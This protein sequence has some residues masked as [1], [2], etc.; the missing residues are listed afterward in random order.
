VIADAG[1]TVV[2]QNESI[3]R[4]LMAARAGTTIVVEPGEYRE[5]LQLKSH[6]RLMSRV[7]RGAV[8]R[9]PGAASEAAAAIVARGVQDA[10]VEGFR[11]V[12]DAA[13]PLGTGILASESE[14][15]ISQVEIS[16]AAKAA[17]DVDKGSRVRAVANEIHDN[18]GA[19][20]AIRAGATATITHNRFA[21]NATAGRA[22]KALIVDANAT[23]QFV[24]NV[25]AVSAPGALGWPGASHPAFIRDNF[26]DSRPQTPARPPSSGR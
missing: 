9:L 24:S 11:I 18:P 10:A 5:T 14:L 1:T 23:V 8:L 21:R 17:I 15:S 2:G 16:G 22:Q 25:F 13:T 7:P 3:A 20:L 6:V 12:G 26:F 4:A 19:A